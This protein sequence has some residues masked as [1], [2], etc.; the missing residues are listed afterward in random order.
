[1]MILINFMHLDFK[2]GRGLLSMEYTLQIE[3]LSMQK[4]LAC[5]TEPF[6]QLV[7]Q[8]SQSSVPPEP[9][10]EYKN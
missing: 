7:Y 6:L 3:Q 9:P 4:Y 1:M 2:G 8:C 5:N 10:S